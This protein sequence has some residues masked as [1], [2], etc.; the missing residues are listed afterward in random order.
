MGTGEEERGKDSTM[1]SKNIF[2]LARLIIMVS[3]FAIVIAGVEGFNIPHGGKS[4]WF[5]ISVGMLL[6]MLQI[7]YL[8]PRYDKMGES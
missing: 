8:K 6:A 1:N 3:A 7:Q 2:L 4:D 5:T